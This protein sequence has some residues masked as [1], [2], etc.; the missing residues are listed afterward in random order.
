MSP[1]L[2]RR[3]FLKGTTAAAGAVLAGPL[4]LPACAAGASPNEKLAVAVVGVAGRGGANLGGV[5]GEHIVALCDVDE[6]NL[7][8]AGERFPKAKR[9][10]DFRKMLGEVEKRIDAVVVS[11]PDHTH[12]P[13]SAMALRMGKHVYCEKPLTHTVHEARVVADLAREKGVATQIGTQI[14]AGNNYRRVVELV[15]GGA[16]GP[17]DEVHVW[18]SARYGRN[19]RPADTPAVPEYLDWD[20][21][22]GPAHERPYHP[23]YL[24]GRWRGWWAFG[25]GALGDFGC[26][27]MDLPFWALGLR[28][29]ESVEADGPPVHAE[30]TP[31]WCIVKYRFPAE[32]DRPAIRLTWYDGGKRPE[33]LLKRDGLVTEKTAATKMNPATWGS[34]VLFVGEKGMLLSDYG[35]HILLPEKQF[36]AFQPPA[37]S[38][39][40]SIGHHK[41]WIRACKTGEPTTCRF[42]YSGPVT[43]TALLG[44]AAYRTG[45]R[46]AWD[47]ANLKATNCPAAERFLRKDYRDG[48]SL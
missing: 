45:E 33:A 47:A 34:G 16:V 6:R 21:W 40:A 38:I 20:L 37:Q 30:S 44:C 24:P 41:E 29:P 46:F 14:H 27:Y 11:T 42:D 12:A 31:L 36:A 8:K 15:R 5:R 9:F 1:C 3:R 17:I 39:P 32:G 23:C 18:S 19:E 25:S 22:L 2:T 35:R 13:A 10:A 28:Y 7:A 48:W 4:V 43:E 26:H